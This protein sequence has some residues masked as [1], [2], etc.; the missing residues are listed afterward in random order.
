[1]ATAMKLRR[2]SS[3]AF[4]VENELPNANN[5]LREWPEKQP[6]GTQ[7]KDAEIQ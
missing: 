1:V 5:N 2:R 7:R 4:S 3:G 6:V